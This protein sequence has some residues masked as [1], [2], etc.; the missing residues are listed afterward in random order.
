MSAIA[1]PTKIFSQGR[2]IRESFVGDNLQHI[3]RSRH[4]CRVSFV[5]ISQ[6]CRASDNRTPQIIGVPLWRRIGYCQPAKVN[7]MVSEGRGFE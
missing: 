1:P 4:Q 2:I 3:V 6:V 5:P 7:V